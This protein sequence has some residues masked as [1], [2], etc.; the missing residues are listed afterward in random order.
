MKA[1]LVFS[2]LVSSILSA[3]QQQL[4]AVLTTQLLKLEGDSG[5]SGSCLFG[6]CRGFF[7]NNS[8]LPHSQTRPTQQARAFTHTYW[9]VM[10]RGKFR[11]V[12]LFCWTIKV[13]TNWT[14]STESFKKTS[15]I[16]SKY[17]Y[18]NFQMNVLLL[19]S[20]PS[21]LTFHK[22]ACEWTL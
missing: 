18:L 22:H 16:Q 13:V 15:L 1:W 4:P 3:Q 7:Q 8:D 14:K 12:T 21:G 2:H 20:F 17:F 9:A 10:R 19:H 11:T 6:C 5:G